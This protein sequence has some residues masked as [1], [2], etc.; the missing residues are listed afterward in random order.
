MLTPVAERGA[1]FDVGAGATREHPRGCLVLARMFKPAGLVLLC[2]VVAFSG[3]RRRVPRTM[4]VA[5]VQLTSIPPPPPM[6]P[7]QVSARPQPIRAYT[8]QRST[9]GTITVR[10]GAPSPEHRWVH[11]QLAPE[12]LMEPFATLVSELVML[13]RPLTF[14]VQECDDFA[15]WSPLEGELVVCYRY[16]DFVR[17]QVG[18][19][20]TRAV[21]AFTLLHEIGH[22]LI[23]E[24]Q[25]PIVGRGED[26]A[27]RF[28]ATVLLS[29]PNSQTLLLPSARYFR[30]LAAERTSSPWDEHGTDG[31]RFYDLLCLAWGAAPEKTGSLGAQ[32]PAERRERCEREFLQARSG[33]DRLLEPHSRVHGGE[34]FWPR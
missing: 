22:A 29:H 4:N 18:E 31:Q 15:S 24:L 12:R 11:E 13:R 9:R 3:C 23:S 33:W 8:S 2:V 20:D 34:T 32:L 1:H 26:A 19:A 7:P 30:K 10:Y 6:P 17:R 5:P 25:L 27:D 14:V 21:F 28:A 16:F